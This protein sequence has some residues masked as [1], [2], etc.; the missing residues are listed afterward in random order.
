MFYEW[1]MAFITALHHRLG[2]RAVRCPGTGYCMAARGPALQIGPRAGAGRGLTKCVP[3]CSFAAARTA[4]VPPAPPPQ[5]WRPLQGPRR[6]LASFIPALLCSHL[7]NLPWPNPVLFIRRQQKQL[8][9]FIGAPPVQALLEGQRPKSHSPLLAP[10]GREGDGRLPPKGSRKLEL[11][12]P[13]KRC[14]TIWKEGLS[15]RQGNH[16][17]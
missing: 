9:F 11:P 3:L 10:T 17:V 12:Q 2:D 4:P 16:C 6:P 8:F 15:S 7:H 13:P 5:G 14:N 1:Q